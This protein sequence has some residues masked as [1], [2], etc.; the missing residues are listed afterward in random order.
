MLVTSIFYFYHGVFKMSYRSDLHRDRLNKALL[1]Q[2][3]KKYQQAD[4]ADRW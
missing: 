4:Y 1:R 2:G 3:L